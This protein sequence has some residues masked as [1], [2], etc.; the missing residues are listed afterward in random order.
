MNTILVA[1][2][3]TDESKRA[4][5]HAASLA[6]TSDAKLVV[7]SVATVARDGRAMGGID[8]VETTEAHQ[9]MLN[10]ALAAVGT[11]GLTAEGQL[12]VGYPADAIVETA[13]AVDADLVVVGSRELGFFERWLGG[14]VSDGVV[15]KARCDVLI[16]H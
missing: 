12:A 6:K 2:D 8:P 9:A 14:S 1:Y 13:K 3:G 15:H 7:T 10:E 16:V 11:E 4:L 5:E